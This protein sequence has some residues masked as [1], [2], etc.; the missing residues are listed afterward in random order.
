M[1]N[2]LFRKVPKDWIHVVQIIS[3]IIIG[4]NLFG[5]NFAIY[6]SLSQFN[7]L[8]IAFFALIF[9]LAVEHY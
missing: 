5:V 7:L 2:M 3:L 8:L 9:S 4:L 6:L 1:A